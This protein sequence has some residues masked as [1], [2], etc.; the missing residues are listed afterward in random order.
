[1]IEHGWSWLSTVKQSKYSIYHYHNNHHHHQQ[2]QYPNH[3][4]SSQDNCLLIDLG[5]DQ[6]SNKMM[7]TYDD[8]VVVI[9]STTAAGTDTTDDVR[10]K[11]EQ[12]MKN[13]R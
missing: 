8:S 2:L 10:P 9:S 4:D 6:T 7:D 11:M 13:N 12:A 5:R 1:M 3:S